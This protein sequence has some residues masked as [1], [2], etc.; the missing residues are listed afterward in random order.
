MQEVSRSTIAKLLAT[1]N[2]TVVQ[3]NVRTA[4]F[5]VKHRILTLPMWA[6][7]ATSTQ[8]HLVGHEVGHA[9]YTPLDGWH[10]AVCEN[11]TGFKTFLNVVEDARIEKLIQRKYPGLRGPFIKSYKK[12]M[13]DGFFGGDIDDIN[14]MPLIDRINVHF[15][16]GLTSGVRFTTEEKAWIPRIETLE[17]WEEVVTLVEELYGEAKKELQ[18]QKE[19]AQDDADNELDLD[20]L[21]GAAGEMSDNMESGEQGEEDNSSYGEAEDGD[22][23]ESD[24]Q[25]ASYGPEGAGPTEPVSQT[26]Q[27][28]RDKIEEEL[29]E[30]ANGQVINYVLQTPDWKDKVVS[31]K[32][33]FMK[34]R[35]DLWPNVLPELE[36]EAPIYYKEWQRVNKKAVNH[37]VK[38]FEMRKSAAEYARASIS[39]TGVIDT[40][41]MNN[42]KLTDDIF[43]RVTILPEGKNHGFIMYLDM[44]GSMSNYMYE[45]VE[46]LLTLV[47]F[48]RQI[49]VP[50]RVYGF[51]NVIHRDRDIDWE[52]EKMSREKLHNTRGGYH[53]VAF[54]HEVNLLELF[55]DKMNRAD[56]TRMSQDL[57]FAYAQNMNGKR[58]MKEFRPLLGRQPTS[59]NRL[60]AFQLGGTPLDHAL[61][62]GMPLAQEFRTA[63]RI[64]VL[65]TILLTDGCSHTLDTTGGRSGLRPYGKEYCT[66][67]SKMNNKSYRIKHQTE[68]N[69]LCTDALLE[70]YKDITGSSV[71]GY[72]IERQTQAAFDNAHIMM[73]GRRASVNYDDKEKIKQFRA[74]GWFKVERP[75]GYTECYIISDRSLTIVDSTME[76]LR[77]DA[78]KARIRTAFK[79]SQGGSKGSRRMLTDLVQR[80]A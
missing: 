67:T 79:K 19:D 38:E 20:D 80:M 17:T 13:A 41:K 51:T 11:G 55:T 46:Q 69:G 77:S 48:A 33:V 32:D 49:N 9:L 66:V 61:V 21:E 40:V 74:Q 34:N 71:I 72:F 14:K 39:K 58:W 31:Y 43:K 45:T 15:K 52:T 42:Y 64:D 62:I 18:K 53:G 47:H 1:E 7:I 23:E 60:P 29:T 44:S 50:F 3:D 5:D 26:D 8:D 6:D 28:L 4:S 30:P 27:N 22:F 10:E 63:N 68:R 36:H 54:A 76:D 73:T 16:C 57:L 56:M 65:N 12:M 37:M 35:T 75:I 70:M 59:Y 24:E 25:E 78:S 2:I